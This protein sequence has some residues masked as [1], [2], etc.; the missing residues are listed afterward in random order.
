LQWNPN[1]VSPPRSTAASV[2]K[3]ERVP[4]VLEREFVVLLSRWER[5]VIDDTPFFS[6]SARG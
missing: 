6:I 2:K 5:G 3:L 1:E 4:A